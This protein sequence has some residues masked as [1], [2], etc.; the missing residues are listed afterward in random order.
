MRPTSGSPRRPRWSAYPCPPSRRPPW[1]TRWTRCPRRPLRRP[2]PTTGWRPSPPHSSP[3]CYHSRRQAA[4]RAGSI[5]VIN[6][7]RILWC[8]TRGFRRVLG[9]G[10]RRRTVTRA[11]GLGVCGLTSVPC[12]LGYIGHA[13][14]QQR[15]RSSTCSPPL[16]T[17]PPPLP[18]PP[19]PP[20]SHAPKLIP[21]PPPQPPT[22]PTPSSPLVY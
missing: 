7:R 18:P 13:S 6:A 19:P 2:R 9:W 12:T 14:I 4:S 11:V 1:C 17:P 22:L 10:P 16:H 15:Q 5:Y 3:K 21:P 20:N 8:M